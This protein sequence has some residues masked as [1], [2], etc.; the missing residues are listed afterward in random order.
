MQERT[1]CLWAGASGHVY[2]YEIYPRHPML[3]PPEPGNY[4]YARV[5]AAGWVP[6]VISAG[7]PAERASLER[8][9]AERIDS[10]QV[11]HIH[12]HPNPDAALRRA[13]ERDLLQRF[14][15]AGCDSSA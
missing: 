6:V 11:T 13:E 15:E 14:R 3:L 9:L 7:E 5:A 2:R 1:C 8:G 12:F 4:I 10:G